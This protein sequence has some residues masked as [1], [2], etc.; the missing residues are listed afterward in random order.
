MFLICFYSSSWRSYWPMK[1]KGWNPRGG[2]EPGD[3][4][5]DAREWPVPSQTNTRAHPLEGQKGQQ[6][7]HPFAGGLMG[8][9]VPYP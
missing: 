5:E 1:D 6:G 9:G 2:R 8:F 7:T 3:S 4:A